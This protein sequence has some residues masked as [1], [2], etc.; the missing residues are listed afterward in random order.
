[1]CVVRP[2]QVAFRA[3]ELSVGVIP[4]FW[5]EVVRTNGLG[6]RVDVYCPLCECLSTTV[7]T[8]YGL[9]V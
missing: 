7:P 2:C 1:M 6:W 4:N 3:P 5:D 9:F 8:F